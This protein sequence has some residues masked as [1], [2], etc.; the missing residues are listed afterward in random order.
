MDWDR[1]EVELTS[2][3]SSKYLGE[4]KAERERLAGGEKMRNTKIT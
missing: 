3:K 2:S 1:E 4:R